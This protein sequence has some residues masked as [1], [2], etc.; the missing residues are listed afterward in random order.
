MFLFEQSR[1]QSKIGT[2]NEIERYRAQSFSFFPALFWWVTRFRWLISFSSS[3]H[4]REQKLQI[5]VWF[6][7][8]VCPATH[9]RDFHN[10]P[11]AALQ[12]AGCENSLRKKKNF[13]LP[14]AKLWFTRSLSLQLKLIEVLVGSRFLKVVVVR[15]GTKVFPFELPLWRRLRMAVWI[16][17]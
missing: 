11:L 8:A 16:E 6:E 12:S 1:L 5:S 15:L 7:S 4:R 2:E 10:D 13:Y 14:P 3:C 17:F 9:M